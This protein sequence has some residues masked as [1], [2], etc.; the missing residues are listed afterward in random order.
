MFRS[1]GGVKTVVVATDEEV[2]QSIEQPINQVLVAQNLAKFKFDAKEIRQRLPRADELLFAM[3]ELA[4]NRQ[5]VQ[6]AKTWFGLQRIVGDQQVNSGDLVRAALNELLSPLPEQ[7]KILTY[8]ITLNV[9]SGNV[10]H[11]EFR[12]SEEAMAF[13]SDF[14][15]NPQ[16]IMNAILPK[17][18]DSNPSQ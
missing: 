14:A 18:D 11:Y 12:D 16:L 8:E 17:R 10:I 4:K 1:E 13:I 9:D 5:I 3:D 7:P 2:Y 6:I 15:H